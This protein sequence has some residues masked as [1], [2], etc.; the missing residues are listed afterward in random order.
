MPKIH[1]QAIAA[2][3]AAMDREADA[4]LGHIGTYK[5]PALNIKGEITQHGRGYQVA[6]TCMNGAPLIIPREPQRFPS[7]QAACRFAK[8]AVQPEPDAY[9][10]FWK[11][12]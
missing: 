12:D 8:E 5:N 2:T 3:I 4:F 11:K 6:L 7:L 1:N 10:T 9:R